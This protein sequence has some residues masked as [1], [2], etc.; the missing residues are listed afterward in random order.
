[1]SHQ[2]D[3]RSHGTAEAW[4]GHWTYGDWTWRLLRGRRAFLINRQPHSAHLRLLH[5][6]GFTVV[7]DETTDGPAIDRRK[8]ASRFAALSEADLTTSGAFIQA[9]LE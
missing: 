8:L 9:R 5:E 7:Y 1:M 2:I 4:N 6:A 3:F